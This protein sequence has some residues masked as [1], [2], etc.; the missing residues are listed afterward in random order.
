MK[1]PNI[2]I[3]RWKIF[4]NLPV[5]TGITTRT[6]GVSKE[7]YSSLNLATHTGDNP[8][9][10]RENRGILCRELNISPDLYTHGIQVHSDTIHIVNE[11]NIGVNTFECDALFTA[12]NSVMLNIYVA[13]CVPVVLYDRSKSPWNVVS[14]RMERYL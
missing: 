11:K 9:S 12:E 13:D 8:E 7:P 5:D 1:S 2:N 10:V 3:L 4:E 6:G 14:L